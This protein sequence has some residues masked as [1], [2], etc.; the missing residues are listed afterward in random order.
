[1]GSSEAASKPLTSAAT[2]TGMAEVSHWAM[3]AMPLTPA[4][5][6]FQYASTPI[7]MGVTAPMPV[8]TMV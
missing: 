4:I 1:M 3:G 2:F 8:I 5:R 6:L 7:P